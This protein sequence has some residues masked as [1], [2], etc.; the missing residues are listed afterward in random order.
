MGMFDTVTAENYEVQVKC[1]GKTLRHLTVGNEVTLYS[2]LNANDADE[3]AEEISAHDKA[4][5]AVAEKLRTAGD[6]VALS[7]LAHPSEG[8]LYNGA[9]TTM[10]DYQVAAGDGTYI[11][12]AG[13]VI[14]E[15]QSERNPHVACFGSAGGHRN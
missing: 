13:G 15:V 10:A 6:Y 7:A 1:F 11:T 8:E 3:L 14:T 2:P 12:V 9:R 4:N 5:E